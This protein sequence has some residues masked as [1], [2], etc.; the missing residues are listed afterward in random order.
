MPANIFVGS[1]F[2]KWASLMHRDISSFLVDIA[3]F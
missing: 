2:A 3:A 1:V